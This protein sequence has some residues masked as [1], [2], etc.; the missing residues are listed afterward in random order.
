MVQAALQ[1]LNPVT[2]PSISLFLAVVCAS[3]FPSDV[4]IESEAYRWVGSLRFTLGTVV[5]IVN[6]KHYR[7]RIS[8]LPAL[9]D[10]DADA[11]ADP[12]E[13]A[14]QVQVP[15]P[16]PVPVPFRMPSLAENLPLAEDPGEQASAERWTSVEGE[17]VLADAT[18][19][20]SHHTTSL[21]ITNAVRSHQMT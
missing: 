7:G 4:D 19:V 8:Y 2:L 1:E 14:P 5:R 18:Q 9:D 11:N 6:L 20:T 16:V 17:F 13:T 10:A 21:H 15:V 3:L 12:A